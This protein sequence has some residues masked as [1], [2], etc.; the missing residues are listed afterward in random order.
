V[1]PPT[2]DTARQAPRDRSRLLPASGIP[3]LYFALAHASLALGFAVLAVRPD[4]PGGFFHHPRMI[5]VIHLLTLGWISSSILGAFYIVAPL[6]LRMPFRPGW[7]DRI[8]FA[9]HAVGVSGMVSHF[10]LGEYSG[11]VWSA[12][13]VAATVLHVGVRA[14]IGL[15]SAPVPW[16]VKLHVALAFVNMAGASVL[17]MIVGL[18]RMYAWFAWPPMTSAFAHAHLAAVGWAVMMVVGLSYRLI[19]MIVPAP[20]PS[21]S[22]M[23][24]S[25]VLLELGVLSIVV[26]LL[27]SSPWVP[28]AALA[29]V[30]G[31]AA[32]VHHVRVIVRHKLPPPAALP[33]PDW[34][35]WQTHVAF[36][37]LVIAATAGVLLSLTDSAARMISLG[38]IYG[39]AGLV[40]FLGQVVMGIQGRLLPLHG[41]Y[42]RFEAGGLTPPD[43]S[44]HTLASPS[45]AMWILITWAAG[46]PLLATGLVMAASVLIS[47]GSALLLAGVCLNA[48]QAITIAKDNKSRGPGRSPGL[49]G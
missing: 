26:F 10:W 47:L 4:L 2:D 38:W 15:V 48:A 25:A 36:V 37:W 17:G 7:K 1:R 35:T 45:L 33:R 16:P 27:Q 49:T 41:W 22:S 46:V 40:G 19:P 9:S 39:V 5:A 23:A 42:R 18:N 3:L 28:A 20:M 32:F 24:L 21:G 34:A 43:R 12:V 11:M 13:L 6:A 8:A 29:I 14:W 30:A 44:A 31:L